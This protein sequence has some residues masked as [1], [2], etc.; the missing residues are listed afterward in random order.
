MKSWLGFSFFP[1]SLTFIGFF[2]IVL[3]TK[4]IIVCN[5]IGESFNGRL[6][7]KDVAVPL[8]ILSNE[9]ENIDA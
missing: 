5:A 2:N 9:I 4:H 1:I 7:I 3:N 6:S 8:L